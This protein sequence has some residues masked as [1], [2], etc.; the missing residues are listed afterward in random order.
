MRIRLFIATIVEW[1][2]AYLEIGRYG[3]SQSLP[4]PKR[5]V[6]VCTGNICRSA[7]A[8]A[9]ARARGI[10]AVSC[11]IDTQTGKPADSMAVARAGAR[12]I[13]LSTHHTT[14]WPDFELAHGDLLIAAQLEHLNAIRDRASR[15]ACRFVLMSS[16]DRANF[17]VIRDPFGLNQQTFDDVFKLID[18]KI[19][20]LV[21]N[22]G[23][24]D[25]G[26][27]PLQ[28][29][30][31]ALSYGTLLFKDVCGRL[32]V[33]TRMH[34]RLLRR[35]AVIVAFHSISRAGTDGVMRCSPADLRTYCRFFSRHMNVVSLTELATQVRESR[36]SPA[37]LAISFDDGYEDN[38]SLGAPVLREFDLPA[39][40]YVTTGLVGSTS[41]AYW[42]ALVGITSRWMSWDQVR[43]L[44]SQGFDLGAH[45]RSHCNLGAVGEQEIFSEIAGS[46]DD[47]V[48]N[49]GVVPRH[50]AVPFGR[51]FVKLDNVCRIARSAGFETVTLC[52]GGL[53][54]ADKRDHSV[55]DRV[56]IAPGNYL[57]PYGWLFDVL[58]DAPAREAST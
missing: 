46:R 29:C 9:V 13:D 33:L 37:T 49:T 58:R 18:N 6:F 55:W 12:G 44:A 20:Y 27:N 14:A 26:R 7:Y 11:G 36:V 54:D 42:D 39:T 8:E 1:L 19:E 2:I 16:L 5:L 56:P 28:V 38:E 30:L 25:L 32:M 15:H 10:A 40:F 52:R 45:T 57:S 17:A 41:Q 34:R 48:T 35:V 3:G 50:F 43:N 53:V 21:S 51:P 22:W 47:I 4:V 23:R 24:K 31:R